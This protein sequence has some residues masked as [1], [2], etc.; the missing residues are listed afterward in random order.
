MRNHIRRPQ[1]RGL[2][3]RA[4]IHTGYTPVWSPFSQSKIMLHPP[5]VSSS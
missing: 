4:H 2:M 1:L 5:A 3:A